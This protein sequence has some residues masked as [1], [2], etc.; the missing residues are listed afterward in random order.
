MDAD[1]A[2]PRGADPFDDAFLEAMIPHH[3]GAIAMA[4]AELAEG[5]DPELRD[6]ARAIVDAQDREVDA[7]RRHLSRLHHEDDAGDHAG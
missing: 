4:R 7:M 1:P 2:A 5:E 3:V 6:L